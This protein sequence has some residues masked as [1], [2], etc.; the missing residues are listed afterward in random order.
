MEASYLSWDWMLPE[1]YLLPQ[2]AHAAFHLWGLQWVDLLASCSPQCKHYYTLESPLPVG[3]LGLNAFNHPWMFQVSYVFPPPALVPLIRYK[4]QAE[5]V[6]G[7]LRWLILVAPC[8]IEAPWLPSVLN[9]LA[10]VPWQCP[11]IKDLIV[12]VLVGQALRGL[13]YLHLTFWLLSNVCYTDRGSFP[14]SVRQWQGQ[15]E[16]LHQRSTSSVERNGQVG[17]L[18]SVYKTMPSLLLN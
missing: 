3:A 16:N 17:V 14:Q 7:Q 15:L 2:M 4:F 5:H 6:K 10:D 8:W 9:I 18:D 13:P 12:D 11:I 1:Y